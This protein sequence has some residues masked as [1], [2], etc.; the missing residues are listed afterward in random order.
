METKKYV[1]LYDFLQGIFLKMESHNLSVGIRIVI[2]ILKLRG[3]G[4]KHE[5]ANI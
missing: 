5:A 4:G 1:Y 3:H 2:L